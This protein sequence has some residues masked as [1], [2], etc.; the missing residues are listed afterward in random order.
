MDYTLRRLHVP[1]SNSFTSRRSSY[2]V[3]YCGIAVLFW[4]MLTVT[5]GC[6]RH[7]LETGF[8]DQSK[9][10]IQFFTPPG[11]TVAVRA[12]PTRSHQ[13]PMYGAFENR[14]EQSP[15]QFCVFNL[16]PGRYEFKYTGAEGLP[17]ASIYGELIVKRPCSRE[18]RIYQ[19]RSF[20]PMALPSEH[21]QRVA[22][23]GDEIFPYRGEAYRYAIDELDFLRL[24][25]GDVIEKV[26]FVADLEK[27]NRTNGSTGTHPSS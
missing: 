3:W 10:Q 26:I 5:A 25:E 27:A 6:S 4:A 20:V 7:P 22:I 15:Q 21:Y 2:A 17:G 19:R 1:N 8:A 11:V 12:C 9:T 24:R 23:Q 18:G 13:I 16:A 14:L